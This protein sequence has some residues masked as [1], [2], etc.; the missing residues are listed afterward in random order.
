M[1]QFFQHLFST[2]FMP[3]SYCLRLP[4]LI[5]LHAASDS[6]IAFSYFLI[7]L[8]LIYLVRRRQDLAFPWMFLLFGTFILSC[9]MTHVLAV[10]TLWHPVYRLDGVV[11]AFTAVVSLATAI[12]L[13]RLTPRAIALPSP[14][15]LR[16]LNAELLAEVAQRREA[17]EQVW[18]LNA[19][20]ESR[21]AERGEALAK[22]ERDVQFILDLLPALVC[23]VDK[24]GYYRR[25]NRT[26][27]DWFGKPLEQIQD[28]SVEEVL[29]PEE[30]RVMR[31]YQNQVLRG[32]PVRFETTIAYPVG[33]R[34]VEVAYTPD[35]D[36]RGTVQG[37]AALITDISERTGAERERERHAR[38][39]DE[40]MEAL[41]IWE[42]YGVIEY[43]NHGAEEV[44]GYSRAE[45]IG[46]NSHEL[47]QT[48]FPTRTAAEFDKLLEVEGSWS[49]ELTHTRSDGRQ[50]VVASRLRVVTEANG[51]KVVLESTRDITESK[52]MDLEL[53]RL[54]ET[55]EAKVRQR[56]AEL[57]EANRELE[58]FSYSVSHDL[59]APLRTV[60][61]FGRILLRDYR[62]KVLDEK[63]THYIDR[64][65]AATVRMGQLIENLLKLSQLGRTSLRRQT[66]DL[67]KMADE[68]WRE[69]GTEDG[70]RSVRF[71]IQP[72]LHANGDERLLG[73]ALRNL[74]ENAWKFTAKAVNAEIDFGCIQLNGESTYFVKDNGA[75]FDMAHAE[76]LFAP[77]QRLHKEK[78]FEG[79]GI[80]L[81]IV[82]RIIHRHGGRI[83]AEGKPGQGATFFFTLA[84]PTQ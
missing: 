69:I 65:S 78:E 76:Q 79:S 61:G 84:E 39:L 6:L 42:L 60:D 72:H 74:F 22:A 36:D 45:A 12:L 56:T 31:P 81:A 67:T 48:I 58:A 55:L 14:L 38:L 66:I 82:Q 29:G 3:H 63:G 52:R 30:M 54:N 57:T 20:L 64:M 49:G 53:R 62:G 41:F 71:S 15:Q 19:E 4:S 9:G 70:T 23:Y 59:R 80:G 25:V 10:W 2:D 37:F 13:L 50:I 47:L 33:T 75:G 8:S 16:D 1:V 73:I 28:H 77:F 83:W 34:T 51:R 32:Q 17:E 21:V 7:P 35:C 26:Y 43:W 40:S 11:K 44:Y 68:L 5:A 46:S 18:R 24:D 27:Q